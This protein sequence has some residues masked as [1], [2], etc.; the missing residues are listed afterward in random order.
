MKRLLRSLAACAVGCVLAMPASA[1]TATYDEGGFRWTYDYYKVD[2]DAFVAYIRRVDQIDAAGKLK[3][4]DATSMVVPATLPVPPIE[5]NEYARAEFNSDGVPVSYTTVIGPT[6][7]SGVAVV[8][9]VNASIWFNPAAQELLASVAVPETV[10]YVEG[11]RDCKSL[12]TVTI[13]ADTEYSSYSFYGTPWMKAQGEFV[14]NGDT[15]VAYQGEAAEVTVPAGVKRIGEDASA[16]VWKTLTSVSLPAGLEEIGSWAF[17]GCEK[18][19]AIDIPDSVISIGNGAFDSCCAL[20]SVTV[21]SKVKSIGNCAFGYCEKLA[22][23]TLPEGLEY[24]GSEAFTYCVSLASIAIPSTVESIADETF[25]CCDLLASVSI[26]ASVEWI[27]SGAFS[28]CVSLASVDIPASVE[29]ISSRAFENCSALATVTG[30][31]G[32]SDLGY[33]VFSDTP[34]WDVTDGIAMAGPIVLGYKGT[35]PATLEIPEGAS[36]IASEAFEGN[37][38]VKAVTFPSTLRRIGDFAFAYSDVETVEGGAGV[39][40]VGYMAFGATPYENSLFS[41]RGNADKP[42]EFIRLGAVLMGYKGVC[43]AEMVI[44]EGVTELAESVFDHDFDPSVSNIVSVTVG[45]GVRRLGDYAFYKN[46]NLKTVT[47]GPSLSSVGQYVF[48]GCERLESVTLGGNLDYLDQ[49]IFAHCVNLQ[50]VELTGSY[51]EMYNLFFCCSNL[52]SVTVNLVEPEDSDD[53]WGLYVGSG[54]FATCPKFEGGTV[55]RAGYTVVGWRD[56]EYEGE[57]FADELATFSIYRRNS[58]LYGD[59]DYYTV[60]FVP[61]WKRVLHDVD[62]DAKFTTEV[63]ATYAGWI[64]DSNGNLAG[65][66]SVKVSKGKKG[67]TSSKAT[68]TIV[69]L[70]GKKVTLKGTIDANGN[71][72]GGLEGLVLTA[73]GLSG[74]LAVNGAKYAADGARDVMK[75]SKDPEQDVLKALNGKV[76]TLVFYPEA[77]RAV[78]PFAN[79]FAG[80]SVSMGAKGKAKLSG[81]MVDGSKVSASAQAVVGD[82]SCCIPVVYSKAKSSFGFLVWID[83]SGAPLEVTSVSD[84][85]GKPTG[86][87]ALAA[88]MELVDFDLL[89]PI[90]E[91]TSLSVA[92]EDLPTS[93]VGVKTEFLPTAEPVMVASSKWTLNKAATIKYKKGVFDQVAYDKGVAGGKTNNSALKLKYTAKSGLFSGSFTIFTLNGTSL[94]KVTAKVCGVVCNGIGY[95]SAVIKKH[96]A[97]PVVIGELEEYEE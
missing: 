35:L 3:E 1:T 67:A 76:W 38:G 33:K 60:T 13:G 89:R 81:T 82:Y 49:G 43:P 30:C 83:R 97:M 66:V 40:S 28:Y 52:V 58:W 86:S 92:A 17:S 96:G 88:Q 41:D 27:G 85:K 47:G 12:S 59:D 32:V 79:G 4:W 95:G 44:P 21:P 42:F 84:W 93:L 9:E 70:G 91:S 20:T 24:I 75:T 34:L 65:S 54:L 8:R 71:G 6:V 10:E 69:V 90:A 39:S 15:L 26:P 45:S 68:A 56:T 14:V 11:F 22:S 16:G 77:G 62:D 53:E 36:F 72:Q 80:L 48:A 25:S 46:E 51:I 74:E 2:D 64:T 31:A 57:E 19:A 73:N 94:K 61:I 87:S 50:G 29:W 63:S 37:S 78:S 55:K 7:V 23:V 18:L 5:T